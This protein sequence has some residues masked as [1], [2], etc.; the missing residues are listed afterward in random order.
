MT[1]R[2][3]GHPTY[4]AYTTLP[5]SHLFAVSPVLSARPQAGPDP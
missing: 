1:V 5:E 2:N 3:L 4:L